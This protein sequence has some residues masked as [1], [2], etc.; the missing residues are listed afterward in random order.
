[1]AAALDHYGNNDDYKD[2]GMGEIFLSLLE[3]LTEKKMTSSQLK[4]QLEDHRA[5]V[6]TMKEYFTYCNHRADIAEVR[7]N[8]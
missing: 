7:H 2:C 5:T 3:H 1:M 6:T 8:I 4:S